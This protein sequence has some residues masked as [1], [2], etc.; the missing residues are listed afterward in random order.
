MSF[1]VAGARGVHLVKSEQNVRVRK[2]AATTTTTAVSAQPPLHDTTRRD[3][4]QYN[5]TLHY[6]TLHSTSLHFTTLHYTAR[7]YTTLH[8]T[9]LNQ[10][11]IQL[12]LRLQLQLQHNFTTLH[13]ITLHYTRYITFS[14]YTAL[15]YATL[16]TITTRI[17]SSTA[18]GGGGSFRTGNL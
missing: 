14:S 5:T 8:Y 13:Y 2:V 6:T 4:T 3:T 18:Q 16:T 9:T 17:A 1:W 10:L 11:Q 15:S 12:Q 7:H